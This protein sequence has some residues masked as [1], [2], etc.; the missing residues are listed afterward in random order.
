[1]MDRRDFGETGIGP[2]EGLKS[3]DGAG[4]GRATASEVFTDSEINHEWV[5]IGI[6]AAA[7]VVIGRDSTTKL[8]GEDSAGGRNGSG[9]MTIWGNKPF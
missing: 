4:T 2:S 1:M 7:L 5:G 6:G 9:L 3:S 8:N